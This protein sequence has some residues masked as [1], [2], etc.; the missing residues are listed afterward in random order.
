MNGVQTH[1][2]SEERTL[3]CRDL[4]RRTLVLLDYD[5][6]L[7]PSSWVLEEALVAVSRAPL[8]NIHGGSGEEIMHLVSAAQAAFV[9]RQ[10]TC[11]IDLIV[12]ILKDGIGQTEEGTV[13]LK[14]ITNG[15]AAWLRQSLRSFLPLF[16][17]YLQHHQVEVL[18]ARDRYEETF[19]D[20][21]IKWKIFC[22]RDEIRS[23]MDFF[24]NSIKEEA[25]RKQSEH[26]SSQTSK[27]AASDAL[28]SPDMRRL[29]ISTQLSTPSSLSSGSMSVE[30]QLS[31]ASQETETGE[32]V[33]VVD[34]SGV[35]GHSRIVPPEMEMLVV[36]IGDGQH[37][38]QA[39]HC[40][41]NELD[42][43]CVSI[44]LMETPSPEVL[45]RELVLVKDNLAK[46]VSHYWDRYEHAGLDLSSSN[47]HTME[48][49]KRGELRY[50]SNL[51]LQISL[52]GHSSSPADSEGRSH[53][54][55]GNYISETE[56][57]E[58]EEEGD[59]ERGLGHQQGGIDMTLEV[60]NQEHP[61][62]AGMSMARGQAHHHLLRG[63]R[64]PVAEQ[65]HVVE[66]KHEALP[67][68]TFKHPE[69]SSV[70]TTT[71]LATATTAPAPATATTTDAIS[72]ED[73][74]DVIGTGTNPNPKQ[75]HLQ[76]SDSHQHLQ[77]Q[78]KNSRDALFTFFRDLP[79]D[80]DANTSVGER[81]KR[82]WHDD[83]EASYS[84]G[85]NSTEGEDD[86]EGDGGYGGEV[87]GEGDDE[88]S[89]SFSPDSST[90]SGFHFFAENAVPSPTSR[91]RHIHRHRDRFLHGSLS[92]T[93]PHFQAQTNSHHIGLQNEAAQA[94][95]Q[96]RLSRSTSSSSM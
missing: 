16:D 32:N 42:V 56:M 50:N 8:N 26:S 83:D 93:W 19:P 18:S 92:D 43:G 67:Q 47:A 74:D 2:V 45:A 77:Q 1:T 91:D 79:L 29:D 85:A 17:Q 76:M 62:E 90:G 60:E 41:A 25:S 69:A 3:K 73:L 63:E 59:V 84:S 52:A 82:P 96:A 70:I 46:I 9:S 4:Q 33:K 44:K 5:D 23:T 27:E 15:D 57:S 51:D 88:T 55:I 28:S 11:A 21:P 35:A 95:A 22:F 12:S 87:E 80:S 53:M 6:T 40:I 86:G 13:L 66:E 75:Q 68:P 20:E 58:G 65:G 34:I 14:V 72:S 24:K 61:A 37:E 10:E 48:E 30:Q 36:S 49:G 81:R 54:V 7:C 71:N 78:V 64:V 39:S 94:Q 89:K 31:G 38:R